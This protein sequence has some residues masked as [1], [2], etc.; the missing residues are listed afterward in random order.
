MSEET[1]CH[2]P[3]HDDDC[4]C[5]HPPMVEGTVF[6]AVG[7]RAWHAGSRREGPGF[8]TACGRVVIQQGH[9][10]ADGI[11]PTCAKCIR[12]ASRRAS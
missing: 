9:E 10:S 7:S 6:R 2:H 11:A 12:T 8:S 3:M 5:G 1:K 4:D